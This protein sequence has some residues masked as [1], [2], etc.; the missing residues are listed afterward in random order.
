M[1][2]GGAAGS[3]VAAAT[4][5]G[6]P[7]SNKLANELVRSSRDGENSEDA[8]DGAGV[9]VVAAAPV[10]VD[11]VSL[12]LWRLNHDNLELEA[13]PPVVELPAAA[14]LLDHDVLAVLA[15]LLDDVWRRVMKL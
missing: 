4:V 9:V 3:V 8:N 12:E 13:P 1:N 11:E 5:G 10:V 6:R 7:G 2:R 14:G 15:E